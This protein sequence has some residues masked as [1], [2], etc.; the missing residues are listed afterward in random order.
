MPLSIKKNKVFVAVSL[1]I[2]LLAINMAVPVYAGITFGNI[3]INETNGLI[4][5]VYDELAGSASYNSLF[6][7]ELELTETKYTP[8]I[9]TC[10]PEEMYYLKSSN[11]LH[12]KNRYGTASY[13]TESKQFSWIET[14]ENLPDSY[15]KE[16]SISVSPDGNWICFIKPNAN[17]EGDLILQ[18]AITK[19]SAVLAEHYSFNHNVPGLNTPGVKW[20]PDSKRLLY[21][22]GD[23]IYFI[24]PS[25]IFEK[26]HIQEEFRKIGVGSINSVNWT[27]T[28]GFIYIDGEIIYFIKEN[29]L[30]TRSLYTFV[31]GKGQVLGR[32]HSKFD[33]Y[34][35]KFWVD[36]DASR[37]V[38][39]SGNTL[40]GYY[41]LDNDKFSYASIKGL[42]SLYTNSKEELSNGVL[43]DC[44]VFWGANKTAFLWVDRLTYDN[45]KKVTTVYA[46][47]DKLVSLLTIN[48]A[49]YPLL[50]PDGKMIA[51][52][53][54][55]S[56][57]IYDLGLWKPFAVLSGQTISSF[58]WESPSVLYVGGSESIQKWTL[59][60]AKSS[61]TCE[62]L[63][64]SSVSSAYWEGN[65]IVAVSSNGQHLYMY[66]FKKQNWS[67]IS[68][69]IKEAESNSNNISGRNAYYRVYTG[70]ARNNQFTN[71]IFIRS[72]SAPGITYT[73]YPQTQI[74]NG[75][76]KRVALVF[77]AFDSSEGLATVLYTLK[78]FNMPAMF[79]INGEFIRRYPQETCQ[80]VASGY[81]CASSFYTSADL[82]N[83]SFFIDKDFIRRGLAR[84]EDE[85]LETTGS[86]LAL[87]WHAPLYR[88]NALI[89]QGGSEAGYKYIDVIS[90]F[91]DLYS[92]GEKSYVET[93]MLINNML[94]RLQ[95]GAVIP[96][97]VGATASRKSYLYEKLD[98]IIQLILNSGYD[99]VPLES[100]YER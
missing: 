93:S 53:A 26:F 52:S 30:F 72:F 49:S 84:N 5:S 98:L 100:F 71:A 41:E 50:S 51:F 32:L 69:P 27:N 40:A 25:S 57:Y 77:D 95:D 38:V 91:S 45:A 46:L 39:I 18:N 66:D 12:I 92:I 24:D 90:G 75:E 96:I 11:T 74:L 99:I 34:K 94:A 48:E 28:E 88:Q 2:A 70:E 97:N 31:L 9:L 62:L 82:L 61:S 76:R 29:E 21:E 85:F 4:F 15:I 37:F 19:E 58:I 60:T 56:L 1:F 20:A 65:N 59:P 73:L 3:D 80:I 13:S 67:E 42:Y 54:G 33:P 64:I 86:E 55:K 63:F 89:R 10:Y 23:S 35:D 78:K 81:T 83:K 7:T 44:N 17:T 43:L 79:F 47:K 68:I 16:G 14:K 36:S 8:K 87:Y 22:K 6:Y